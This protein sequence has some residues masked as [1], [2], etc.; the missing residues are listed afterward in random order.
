MKK[1]ILAFVAAVSAAVSFAG[2]HQLILAGD[3]TLQHRSPSSSSASWGEEAA[4]AMREGFTLV[5]CAKGGRSTSTFRPD[6]ETNVLKRIR[7]G[8]WVIIQFGHNDMSKA[9]DPKAPER[10]TDPKTAYRDNLRRYVREV[11]ERGGNPVLVT[12]ITLYLWNKDGTMREQNPLAPWIEGM[13]AVAEEEKVPLVDLNAASLAAQR[14]AGARRSRKWFM[15]AENGKDWAH[16]TQIGARVFAN[17][18]LFEA[19][20]LCGAFPAVQDLDTDALQREIDAKSSAG[21]GTVEVAEGLWST[22]QIAL[23]SGVTLRIPKRCTLFGSS[24]AKEYSGKKH[25]V[26]GLIYALNASKIALVGEGRIDGRGEVMPMPGGEKTPD[27]DT[28]WRP[29]LIDF[30]DCR[31]VRVEGLT[32]GN[33]GSWTLH[34]IR[35]DGVTIRNVTLWSHMQHCNDGLDISSSNVLIE[36]CTIDADDDALVFKTPKPDVKVEN[37]EVRNCTFASS[38]NAIKF[39]TETHGTIRNVSIH[40][41]RIVPPAAHVRFDW[42]ENP[43]PGSADHHPV[44][45]LKEYRAGLAGVAVETVDGGRLENVTVRNLTIDGCLTPIFVRLGRRNPPREGQES[46]LRNVLFE[47]IKGRASSRIACSITGVP[48]LRPK[49]VV[50]KNVDLSFPGGGTENDAMEEVPEK[51]TNYP[52]CKMFNS[53]ALPAYGFYVRHADGVSFEGVKMRFSGE[54]YRK[55]VVADDAD[56]KTDAACSFQPPTPLPPA[57]DVVVDADGKV[58]SDSA[59]IVAEVTRSKDYN[60]FAVVKVRLASVPSNTR[61]CLSV[62]KL[63]PLNWYVLEDGWRLGKWT[64]EAL[65]KGVLLPRIDG[66]VSY[67]ITKLGGSPRPKD[68]KT[69]WAPILRKVKSTYDGTEQPLYFEAPAKAKSEPVPLIVGLHTWSSDIHSTGNYVPAREWAKSHGWAFVGP[70]FRGANNHPEACGGEPAVQDIVDAVEYAKVHA[71]IDAKRIY[72]V[73]GSGGGH[74]T[75]LM[76]GRHP[77]IWAGCAAF[78]PISDVAR[79]HADSLLD[80][81]GRGKGYAKM[82]ELS[83]GGTPADK[84]EEYAKR[85]PLTHLAAARKAGVPVY[86][87]TGIHDGWVGSVPVGH[88]IRAFNALADESKR[89]SEADIAAIEETQ[90]IPST[91]RSDTLRDSFYGAHGKNKLLFRRTSANVRL[92]IFD[93]GHGGNYPAGLDFLSRQKKGTPADFTLPVSAANPGKVTELTK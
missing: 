74:M 88:A 43:P 29:H 61:V 32:I 55:P 68:W 45:G 34:P 80:H 5:N 25:P 33:G 83:C 84:P 91:L 47:N 11:R 22:R 69:S 81:P 53:Q 42:R 57:V 48:G 75:L 79:W 56:V 77:E 10:R 82:L 40:D 73:G 4:F 17:L 85:S 14:I 3:S 36:N 93:G 54:E 51:E 12:S 64:N 46:F 18:F 28:S 21:G 23:K 19:K 8:D 58:V 78:C 70:H 44:P 27:W 66:D 92:S 41:C 20:G 59:K 35:C 15:I 86:I 37:V 6:W 76:A 87:V 89:V 52:E 62:K 63:P 49:G 39:G 38:C 24:K 71:K 1:Q 26:G 7:S 2:E 90:E 31:D 65:A 9:S 50:L 60:G 67:S 16:P 13:K 30:K 72:I